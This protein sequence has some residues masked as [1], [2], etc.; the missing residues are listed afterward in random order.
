MDICLQGDTGLIMWTDSVSE[1]PPNGGIGGGDKG[2]AQEPEMDICLYRD[3]GFVMGRA[4]EAASGAG[5][6][7]RAQIA[8]GKRMELMDIWASRALGGTSAGPAAGCWG[9]AATE[10]LVDGPDSSSSSSSSSLS[11][12]FSSSSAPSESSAS[13]S[14]RSELPVWPRSPAVRT[15]E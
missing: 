2:L 1:G 15:E 7:A 10:G 5:A 3:T 14:W 9:L 6:G 13:E 11:L 8:E 4:E 12:S